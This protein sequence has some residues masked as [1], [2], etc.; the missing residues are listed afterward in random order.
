MFEKQIVVTQSL[1]PNLDLLNEILKEIWANKW[2]TNMR[3][4]HTQQEMAL[5]DY[6]KVPYI[7]LFTNDTLP[8]STKWF[9]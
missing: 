6:L 9:S 2:I 8:L 4:F 1:L 5:C 3:H 7:S